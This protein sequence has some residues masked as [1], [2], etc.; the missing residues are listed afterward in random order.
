MRGSTNV[1]VGPVAGA[2]SSSPGQPDSTGGTASPAASVQP[3]RRKS[4]RDRSLLVVPAMVSAMRRNSAGRGC[5]SRQRT[6]LARSVAPPAVERGARQRAGVRFA[7]RDRL[8]VLET[9]NARRRAAIRAVVRCRAVRAHS[10]PTHRR[11]PFRRARARS[12]CRR[13]RPAPPREARPATGVAACAGSARP[14]CPCRLLPHAKTRPSSVTA[15]DMRRAGRDG[16]EVFCSRNRCGSATDSRCPS[17][18]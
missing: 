4:R 5:M 10:S 8:D 14:S 16:A 7:R 18:S 6:D 9:G 3:R 11:F 2:P 1:S 13:R 17:P 12:A 15:S